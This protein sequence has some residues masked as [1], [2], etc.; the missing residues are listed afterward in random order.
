MRPKVHRVWVDAGDGVERHVWCGAFNMSPGDVIPL[1]TPG[2]G[3]AR[4]SGH[5]AAPDPRHRQPGHAVLGRANSA[6]ATTTRASSSCRRTRRSVCRTARPS[7]SR[8]SWCSTSTSPGTGPTAGVISG[9]PATSRPTW[10][11]P[12]RR[13]R[14]RS[15]PRVT[16]GRPS[17]DLV[18]GERWPAVHHGGA[19]GRS[20]GSVTA[21]DGTTAR[22]SRHAIDQQR[23]RR[24]QLRDARAQP[25]QPRLRPR[26]PR[27]PRVPHPPGP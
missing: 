9:P 23:G 12:W 5:R 8:P 14:R 11:S 2:H 19:V 25:T 21:M 24:E 13:H 20:G 15:T 26:H 1:A 22:R 3:H 7:A 18:D 6:S 16:L 17:V 4:R 27:R 10:A